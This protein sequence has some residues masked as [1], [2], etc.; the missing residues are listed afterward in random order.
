[1]LRLCRRRTVCERKGTRKE[2]CGEFCVESCACASATRLAGFSGVSGGS[3][4][5]KP[6]RTRAALSSEKTRQPRRR[7]RGAGRPAGEERAGAP[8]GA[9]RGAWAAEAETP[10]QG[11]LAGSPREGCGWGDTRGSVAGGARCV[12]VSKGNR[13]VLCAYFYQQRKLLYFAHGATVTASGKQFLSPLV[14]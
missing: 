9:P 2:A 14:K 7:L 10:A 4:T 13:F 3:V 8:R 6:G 11:P 5:L 12:P 1:M